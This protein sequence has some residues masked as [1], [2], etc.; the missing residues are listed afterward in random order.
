[1]RIYVNEDRNILLFTIGD[2]WWQITVTV[3]NIGNVAYTFDPYSVAIDTHAV[4]ST[5]L[6]TLMIERARQLKGKLHQFII[7]FGHDYRKGILYAKKTSDY[8]NVDNPISEAAP[9]TDDTKMNI[10]YTETFEPTYAGEKPLRRLIFSVEPD[11][12]GVY[13]GICTKD[14]CH[15][16]LRDID[17][18]G[19]K[20]SNSSHWVSE[21][22]EFAI[23][24]LKYCKDSCYVT[25]IDEF[26][27]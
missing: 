13:Y 1:V 16:F 11:P 14:G 15:Q 4:N 25:A 3:D 6:E 9:M 17:T 18:R 5:P 26:C 19:L 10:C 23:F 8:Y 27:Y 22:K 20:K 7:Y 24:A 12:T 2:I 21:D